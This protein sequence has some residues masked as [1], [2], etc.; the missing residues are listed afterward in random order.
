MIRP[1]KQVAK[2]VYDTLCSG[3]EEAIYRNAMS[4]ELQD[5]GY[6][7]KT[8]VPI[9]IRYTTKKGREMIVCR[10]NISTQVLQEFYVVATTKLGIPSEM[11]LTAMDSFG[12]LNVVTVTPEMIRGAIKKQTKFVLSFWDAL[13]LQSAESSLSSIL[14]T[15]D[16][17][18]GQKYD[19]ISIMNPFANGQ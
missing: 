11:V 19:S 3:H 15:E 7:V 18:D 8:E 13:I 9:S 5:R 1:I 17:N 12:T 10:G 16:L 4:V 2:Y 14:Y 6:T